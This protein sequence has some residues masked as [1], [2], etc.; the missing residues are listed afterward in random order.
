MCFQV[1]EEGPMD[2]EGANFKMSGGDTATEGAFSKEGA[3]H[4]DRE[5]TPRGHPQTRAVL[6]SSLL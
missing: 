4:Q 1:W 6:A 3:L 2:T 5:G